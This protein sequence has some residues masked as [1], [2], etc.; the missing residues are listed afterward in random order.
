M[1]VSNLDQL[2]IRLS[3]YS[4]SPPKKECSENFCLSGYNEPI[5]TDLIHKDQRAPYPNDIHTGM[6][7]VYL[8]GQAISAVPNMTK[9]T[10]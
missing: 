8:I 5:P 10:M 9:S 7:N 2:F 6:P 4:K 3:S 1:L